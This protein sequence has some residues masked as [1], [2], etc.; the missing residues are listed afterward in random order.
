MA[1][2]RN[3]NSYTDEYRVEGADPVISAGRPAT[4]IAGELGIP[5]K[6]LQGWVRARRKR[7]DGPDLPDAAPSVRE[8]MAARK[9]I[10]E[11]ERENEFLKKA[12]AF[13]A[14]SQAL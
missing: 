3:G 14:R 4:E 5:A 12:S 10:A 9:R 2:A 6:T 8:L 13:F 7:L 1:P 11:L